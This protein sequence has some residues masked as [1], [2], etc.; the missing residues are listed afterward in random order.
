MKLLEPSNKACAMIRT[1][2]AKLIISFE[3]NGNLRP[4][5][6]TAPAGRMARKPKPAEAGTGD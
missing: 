3:L 4:N 5:G 2:V 1:S 6:A